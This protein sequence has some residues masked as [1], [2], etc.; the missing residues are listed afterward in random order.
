MDIVMTLKLSRL[1]AFTYLFLSY[2]LNK[3]FTRPMIANVSIPRRPD[4]F[5]QG[6]FPTVPKF[7]MFGLCRIRT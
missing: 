4:H 6:Y 1:V 2:G 3:Q 5:A 7:G